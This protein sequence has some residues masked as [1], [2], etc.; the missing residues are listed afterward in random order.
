MSKT[1]DDRVRYLG[2]VQR[3]QLKPDDVLVVKLATRLNEET[4]T[5]LVAHLEATLPNQRVLVLD[6]GMDLG[7]LDRS[8]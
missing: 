3:L 5:R 2:D 6:P 4:R 7:V 8:G 1:M